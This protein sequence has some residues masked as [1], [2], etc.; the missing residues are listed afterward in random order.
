MTL[1]MLSTPA[2]EALV[3]K[4]AKEMD[5]DTNLL[6]ELLSAAERHSGALRRKSLFQAFDTLLDQ[7]SN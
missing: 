5:L 7:A 4:L 2:S 6:V 3:E 1:P